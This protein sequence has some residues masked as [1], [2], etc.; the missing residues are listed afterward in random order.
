VTSHFVR[1]SIKAALV[2]AAAGLFAAAA[3]APAAH[4]QNLF[5]ALFGSFN[6]GD[7]S[8]RSYG[9]DDRFPGSPDFR[10]RQA[11]REARSGITGG[12][13][14]GGGATNCVR[15]CDGRHFP[16]PRSVNGVSLDSGKVCTALCPMA[17]TQVFRGSDMEYARASDGTRY[18]D[19]ENAFAYRDRIVSDCSCTGHGPGGLAQIDVESDPTLRAGDVVAT[20]E[21]LTVFKGARSFPYQT[22]DFTP[23]DSYARVNAELRRKLADVKV[24]PTATSATPVQSLASSE[25]QRPV[26]QHRRRAPVRAARSEE[27]AP[28]FFDSWFR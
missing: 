1:N 11:P 24:D 13:G 25:E 6:D 8:A 23:I 18:A 14:G 22:A 2:A 19:L 10:V 9:R 5:E 21:G 4:A 20:A 27:R 15:L 16:V 12:G 26:V 17:K 28:S 7:S 3:P